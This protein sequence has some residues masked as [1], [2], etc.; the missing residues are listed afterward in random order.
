MWKRAIFRYDNLMTSCHACLSTNILMVI[1][2]DHL[3]IKSLWELSMLVWCIYWR[4]D[5]SKV[6]YL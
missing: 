3:N 4:F 1:A 5:V 2:V 6:G